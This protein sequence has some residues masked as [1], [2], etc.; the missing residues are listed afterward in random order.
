M[1]IFKSY[2]ALLLISQSISFS[3]SGWQQVYTA[4]SNSEFRSMYFTTSATGYAVSQWSLFKTTNGGLNWAGIY[5]HPDLLGSIYFINE[6]T[7][8]LSSNGLQTPPVCK[9]LKT[10]NAG[11]NWSERY[12]GSYNLIN[13]FFASVSSG[14]VLGYKS[15]Y[16]NIYSYILYTGNGGDNW[17]IVNS[18]SGYLLNSVS[19]KNS[20][21]GYIVGGNPNTGD[22]IIK[23]SNGGQNWNTINNNAPPLGKISFWE[24]NKACGISEHSIY[25]SNNGGITWNVVFNTAI[26]LHDMVFPDSLNGYVIGQGGIIYKTVNGGTTWYTQSS[27]TTSSLSLLFFVNS[28]TGYISGGN[29]SIRFILKTTDG[30]GPVSIQPISSEIP[31]N[32]SLSQNYPNPFNPST[33]INFQ[34]SKTNHVKLS[35]FDLLGREAAVLV[36]EELSPGEYNVDFDGANYPSGIYYYRLQTGD[37]TETRK[38]VLIK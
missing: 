32:F 1:K 14:I 30:G 11:L 16:M 10:T 36:N 28:Q 37:F 26:F 20:S 6:N 7:G 19:F 31:A 34:M 4:S 9:I 27:G 22:F 24:N 5:V 8:F 17:T 15:D 21:T 29:S 33:N 25:K 23:T 12:S 3:Q 13:Y 2:L 35:V 38:M 18:Y